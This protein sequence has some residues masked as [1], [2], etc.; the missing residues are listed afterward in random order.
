M[1]GVR[2]NENKITEKEPFLKLYNLYVYAVVKK[3]QAETIKTNFQHDFFSF[4]S[5]DYYYLYDFTPI[6]CP[7]EYYYANK[8]SMHTDMYI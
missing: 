7:V 3:K 2:G 8:H 1:G 4:S 5:S 6:L